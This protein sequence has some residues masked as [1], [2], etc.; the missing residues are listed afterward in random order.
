[1]ECRFVLYLP[2]RKAMEFKYEVREISLYGA[3]SITI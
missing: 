1:M 3:K 2:V